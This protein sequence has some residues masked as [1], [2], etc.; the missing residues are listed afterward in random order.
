M[1]IIFEF[2]FRKTRIGEADIA[3]FRMVKMNLS[4][5]ILLCFVYIAMDLVGLSNASCSSDFTDVPSCTILSDIVF[6]GH[7]ISSASQTVPYNVTFHVKKL[8]KGAL[9]QNDKKKF[10]PI[11]VG[12]FGDKENSSECI[13]GPVKPK[14]KYLVF[15]KEYNFTSAHGE[16]YRI[17]CSSPVP[18]NKKNSKE[19]STSARSKSGKL[20]LRWS[21]SNIYSG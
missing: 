9:R 3:A 2:K 16:S 6:E 18:A 7:P 19:A 4:G 14:T 8:H 13:S 10:H 11:S 17:T 5:V 1:L 21:C 15:L 20:Y 12:I